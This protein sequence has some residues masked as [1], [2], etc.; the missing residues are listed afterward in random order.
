MIF[1]FMHYLCNAKFFF[2]LSSQS[3]FMND[4]VSSG[5]SEYVPSGAFVTAGFADGS[6]STCLGDSGSPAVRISPVD[7][8]PE[9]IGLV[10]WSRGCGRPFRPS[11]WTRVETHVGWVTRVMAG[12]GKD[13]QGFRQANARF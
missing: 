6:A 13:Q 12:M 10:S 7:G 3:R 9:V 2:F 5:S 8:D 4:S 1:F 11:V